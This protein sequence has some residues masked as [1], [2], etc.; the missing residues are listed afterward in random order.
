[1]YKLTDALIVL[2]LMALVLM[3][4]TYRQGK[5]W[6]SLKEAKKLLLAVLPL[7]LAAFVVVG[8]MD[9]LIPEKVL[10]TW[11]GAGSGWR[12]L[13]AGPAI[14]A[15]IQ[16]GPYAFFPLFDAVFRESVTTGTAIAMISAW[17]MINVGH[18]PYEFAFLGPRFVIL[19]YALYLAVPSLAGLVAD[20][21]FG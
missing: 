3:F 17:G 14:G 13:I 5:H 1:M 15:L 2:F 7:L 8:F 12:G 16:G 21:L 18:L 11:L 9:L 6:E 4:F 20:V 19:K 10:Q